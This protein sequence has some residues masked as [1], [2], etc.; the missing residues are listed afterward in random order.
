[1]TPFRR[2]T[3]NAFLLVAVVYLVLVLRQEPS[4]FQLHISTGK[5]VFG[6][7]C[8]T[9]CLAASMWAWSVTLELFVDHRLS[10]QE[11]F[12]QISVS[13]LGKYIPGKVWGFMARAMIVRRENISSSIV[14][15]ASLLEHFYAVVFGSVV[16]LSLVLFKYGLYASA[17]TFC[18]LFLTSTLLLSRLPWIITKLKMLPIFNYLI[19]KFFIGS[20]IVPNFSV[21]NALPF[22]LGSVSLVAVFWVVVSSTGLPVPFS[23]VIQLSGYMLLGV[24]VGYLAFFVPGGIGVREGVFVALTMHQIGFEAATVISL[25]FRLWL[26]AYDL[27]AGISG[28]I[29]DR[30]YSLRTLS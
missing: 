1:M 18:V 12:S 6:F 3:L 14:I 19:N 11:L 9:M 5:L 24:V 29:L 30:V 7:F 28:Y 4:L 8:Q 25:T 27:V 20:F 2:F 13:L 22:L 21:K 15:F 17:L 26:S 23:V 16:G 10:L